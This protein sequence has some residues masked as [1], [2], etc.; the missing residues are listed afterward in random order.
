M[1][2]KS[3]YKVCPIANFQHET[4][5]QVALPIRGRSL[6]EEFL[7]L[8]EDERSELSGFTAGLDNKTYPVLL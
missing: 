2:I 6:E 7:D 8:S 4:T 1:A 5:T 3:R